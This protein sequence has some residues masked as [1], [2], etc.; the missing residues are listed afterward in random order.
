MYRKQNV[1]VVVPAYNEA[2]NV[3]TVV[4]TMP[5]YVDRLFVVDDA[6]TDATWAAVRAGARADRDSRSTDTPSTS[7]ATD[8]GAATA[9]TEAREEWGRTVAIRHDRQRGAGGAIKTGYLAALAS[10]ADAVATMDGDGQMDPSHLA[11]LLDVLVDT[12][13]TY[14]KGTRLSREEHRETMPTFRLFGNT[15]LTYLT[16]F[17]SGYWDVADPQNGF[18]AI[19]RRALEAIDV[20]DLYEYY[21]YCNQLL[22]RLNVQG[23]EVTD[24]EIPAVY[25]DEESDI[26]YH[27]YV[28]RVGPMLFRVWCWRLYATYLNS[29]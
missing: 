11:R 10:E 14:A 2:A 25:G 29:E 4:E 5:D 12:P 13:A 6:S 26:S 19:S 23:F 16:K 28:R 27:R 18:T 20:E 21:G 1:A 3:G 15:L 17:A 24:V 22:A 9:R 7:L 8:G